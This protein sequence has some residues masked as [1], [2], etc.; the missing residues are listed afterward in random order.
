M[1]DITAYSSIANFMLPDLAG[2]ELG[3]IKMYLHRA[4]NRFCADSEAWRREASV[5]LVDGTDTYDISGTDLTVRR[6]HRVRF[7]DTSVASAKDFYSGREI[8]LTDVAVLRTPDRLQFSTAATPNAAE[9]GFYLFADV[10]DVP[11]TTADIL[12]DYF[13]SR[14]ADA[15]RYEAMAELT[16]I[17][18]RPWTDLNTSQA[19]YQ[20]Y[21]E[22][23]N[24]ARFE[25]VHEDKAVDLRMQAPSFI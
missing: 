1:A 11:D 6:V 16:S 17:P 19:Y 15:L 12:P 21:L 20:K 2:C 10:S 13:I 8:S 3:T 18:N 4:G 9:D 7:I 24:R 25:A 5:V 23:V 22:E 14:W